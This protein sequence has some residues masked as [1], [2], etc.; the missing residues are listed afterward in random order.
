MS[1]DSHATITYTSMSSYEVI[2]NGYYGMPMDPLDPYVQLVMDAPP[3]PDYIPGHEVPPSPDY[4]PGPEAPLSPNYIPR[5][6]YPEYL[7]PVDD[8]LPA[9]EQPLPAAVS[10]TAESPGYI[11][12]SE[13]EMELEEEDG[14]DEK[15]EDD[16][17]E[18]PTSRGDDDG[19]D[20]LKDDAD[21]EDKEDSSDSEEEEEEHLASTVPASALY[22]SVS[23]FEETEPFEEGETAATPPLSPVSPTSYPLPL[24]LMRLPIF[25]PLPTS[26]FPLPL[27]LPSTFGSESIPEVDILLRKRAR[28]TTP[29]GGYEVGESFVAAA[30]RQIRPALTIADRRRGDDR[31]I[32]RLR[33]EKRYFRTLSTTYAQEVAHSQDYCTQIM[34]Y[35]QSRER[36]HIDDE[37]RLTRHIQHEHAQRDVAP[38]DG[39]SCS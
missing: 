9:E 15:S 37:D 28:F 34:D 38:E 33:R 29:T 1:S 7:P 21:D 2:V 16:S 10:P 11:T 12:E 39:N 30:A 27:S 32:S 36:Q 25:T 26:S 19:D 31:L 8:V 5:P 14:D 24:F 17:I 18:Y 20:L 13:P 23:A 6:E 22:S 4:I 3:S 35:C